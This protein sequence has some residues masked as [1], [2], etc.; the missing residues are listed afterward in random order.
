MLR[1]LVVVVVTVWVAV[2]VGD[3]AVNE[4]STLPC[5]PTLFSTEAPDLE[6]CFVALDCFRAMMIEGGIIPL[7]FNISGNFTG[8]QTVYDY[9]TT[10]C[11]YPAC[12][13][14]FCYDGETC[15]RQAPYTSTVNEEEPYESQ[16]DCLSD[17]GDLY[18]N[19]H[20]MSPWHTAHETCLA[21]IA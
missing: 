11:P 4:A 6:C 3:F 8:N 9:V 14:G 19:R 10:G 17:T 1:G 5:L 18:R 13:N 2:V 21:L 16:A 7:T 12:Q 15:A 20:C